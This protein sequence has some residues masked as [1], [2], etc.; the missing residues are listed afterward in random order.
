MR[1]IRSNRPVSWRGI[2]GWRK[3]SIV[4]QSPF[5][6][7]HVCFYHGTYDSAGTCPSHFYKP[8]D[9]VRGAKKDH[10]FRA[11]D[12]A[13]LSIISVCLPLSSS[14]PYRHMSMCISGPTSMSS[15]IWNSLGIRFHLP[16]VSRPE[17]YLICNAQL[18]LHNLGRQGSFVVLLSFTEYDEEF[19]L[20]LPQSHSTTSLFSSLSPV[21]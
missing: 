6:D 15:D 17:L 16:R 5:A 18:D 20:A 8:L 9:L 3:L 13:D 12:P 11:L 21:S 10:R 2:T 7:T 14:P 1:I 4:A 19:S